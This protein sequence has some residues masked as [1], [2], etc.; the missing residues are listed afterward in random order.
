MGPIAKL[1]F[2][3]LKILFIWKEIADNIKNRV[4]KKKKRIE[5]LPYS[6]LNHYLKYSSNKLDF[7]NV[8]LLKSLKI[9]C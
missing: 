5:Y 7:R 2:S 1:S 4:L 9:N 8:F 3:S 6:Y